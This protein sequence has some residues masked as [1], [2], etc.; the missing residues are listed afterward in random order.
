M[1]RRAG[2]TSSHVENGREAVE[3]IRRSLAGEAPAIDLVLMD[4][5]MPGLDGLQAACEVRRLRDDPG[6]MTA[7]R[8]CPP[9]IAVT[10]N[11]FAEDRRMC[12]EA[13]MD[14]Y[15]SKPFSWSE[16]DAVLA[17]WLPHR[18][19]SGNLPERKDH[20]A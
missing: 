19:Q 3:S 20:A 7:D 10:A 11:A 12:M 17:R 14:D 15:L 9:L 18:A 13:G 2:C 8:P 1:I 6:A 4:V 16:F 5:H